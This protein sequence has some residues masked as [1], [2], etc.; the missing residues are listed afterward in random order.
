M[1][2]IAQRNSISSFDSLLQVKGSKS[3]GTK[4][5]FF[6]AK[7]RNGYFDNSKL[8][9]KV[10]YINFWFKNCPPCMAEMRSL[11][12]LNQKM[13]VYKGFQFVSFTFENEKI[14]EEIRKKYHI[15][16][17]IFHL[18]KTDCY[19]LNQDSGFPVHIILDKNG[20]IQFLLSGYHTKSKD[21]HD[22]LFSKVY[23]KI[24]AILNK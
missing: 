22:Y 19:R 20:E 14:I 18:S 2:S 8:I 23:P 13:K 7:N 12:Q 6:K 9:G 1:A 24:I 15:D 16:Y 11:R 5:P 21:A 3:I 4:F 10:T 17:N